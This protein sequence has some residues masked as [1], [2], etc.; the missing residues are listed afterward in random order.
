M[1]STASG[2]GFNSKLNPINKGGDTWDQSLAGSLRVYSLLLPRGRI[3]TRQCG[4]PK[5]H[6]V[7][8]TIS[9]GGGGG[10]S[11]GG[12]WGGGG[13]GGWNRRRDNDAATGGGGQ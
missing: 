8:H 6:W 3:T 12:G 2:C 9:R 13:P 10:V 4:N 1:Q 11:P 7:R 5:V